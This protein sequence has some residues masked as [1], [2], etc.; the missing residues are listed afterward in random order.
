MLSSKYAVKLHSVRD[1]FTSSSGLGVM[2]NIKEDVGE[3]VV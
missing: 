3:G 2:K 1:N